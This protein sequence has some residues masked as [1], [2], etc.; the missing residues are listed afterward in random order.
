MQGKVVTFESEFPVNGIKIVFFVIKIYTK[1]LAE[2]ICN[3]VE[4]F[5]SAIII[6]DS[7]RASHGGTKNEAHGTNFLMVL[8]KTWINKN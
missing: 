1:I 5:Q 3:L 8:Y 4:A 7:F 6:N 2:D